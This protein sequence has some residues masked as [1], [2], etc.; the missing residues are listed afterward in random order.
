M[1]I[2]AASKAGKSTLTS[3]APT[4]ILVLD[5]E[6]S[7]KFI[8]R[9]NFNGA[10]LRKRK[11]NPV[12]GPPP[13]YDGTWDVCHVVVNDWATLQQA[14]AWLTQAPHQFQS[15]VIDSVTEV[16]RRC[17]KN[18]VGTEA[19]KIQDWGT[20]LTKMDDLIRGYRDL[21]LIAGLPVRCVVII[22][23]TTQGEG[24]RWK[25]YMQGQIKSSLPYWVDICGYLYVDQ[26]SDEQGQ[27]TRKVRR[28]L[29]GPHPQYETGERVQGT[30]PDVITEP[31]ITHMMQTVYDN[32][33][34]RTSM[35]EQ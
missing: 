12:S 1:L 35:E 14:Y 25:P 19:M 9:V 11:W 33:G 24:G 34:V 30:L 6:G 22:A 5:A 17:K 8:G 16:Q 27:P 3:S 32:A 13:Q 10:P 4:P 2:H 29:I 18:L 23:E 31:N 21:T 20:L 7:W 15:I 28:L 26:E